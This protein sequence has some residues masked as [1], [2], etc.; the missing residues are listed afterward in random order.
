VQGLFRWLG[1]D[2]ALRFQENT[3]AGRDFSTSNTI[4]EIATGGNIAFLTDI[5]VGGNDVNLTG[6]AAGQVSLTTENT[7]TVQ[8]QAS[9]AIGIDSD[10]DGTTA[11]FK[12]Q[13]HTGVT[14][15]DLFTVTEAGALSGIST[16]G[17]KGSITWDIPNAYNLA[18]ATNRLEDIFADDIRLGANDSVLGTQYNY[19]SSGYD[20]GEM[21]IY[22][23]ADTADDD[24]DYWKVQ[25]GDGSG[26][27]N[28]TFWGESTHFM[29]LDTDGNLLPATT[30]TY[31]IGSEALRWDRLYGDLVTTNTLLVEGVLDF[32]SGTDTVSAGGAL[33]PTSP[34]PRV[35]PFGGP[36]AGADSV[37]SIVGD[38]GWYTFRAASASDPI[39][40]VD[41]NGS[42]DL[43]GDMVLDHTNDVLFLMNIGSG[44]YIEVSR[45]NNQ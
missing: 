4:I 38:S 25:A 14:P 3:A 26:G 9:A 8:S 44:E 40:F 29:S 28:L 32:L 36:D 19:G 37:T 7:L 5:A 34:E 10:N 2:T 39:T 22:N 6:A 42:L 27:G 24:V 30:T 1:A 31:D 11:T 21:R 12:V 13:R 43:A 23:G 45:S 18:D 41:N 20:G 33:T 17:L 15:V 35:I 16:L